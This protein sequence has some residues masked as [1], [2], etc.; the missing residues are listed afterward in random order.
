MALQSEIRRLHPGISPSDLE[1]MAVA[2]VQYIA[3]NYVLEK[4]GEPVILFQNTKVNSPIPECNPFIWG[5]FV[6]RVYI[7]NGDK[8]IS[9][10]VM[11]SRPKYTDMIYLR[12]DTALDNID[13]VTPVPDEYQLSVDSTISIFVFR[14]GEVKELS[15]TVCEPNF[16]CRNDDSVESIPI[17]NVIVN[18]PFEP[19]DSGAPAMVS[20]DGNF[21][22]LGTLN[23]G[24][25]HFG[26]IILFGQTEERVVFGGDLPT[27]PY[28]GTL[29]PLKGPKKPK[30]VITY[31]YKVT[32][33]KSAYIEPGL[34]ES[35]RAKLD[36]FLNDLGTGGLATAI[37]EL[38]DAKPQKW[39]GNDDKKGS[40][41]LRL[42]GKNRIWVKSSSD[43]TADSVTTTYT[44]IEV[45]NRHH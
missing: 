8:E 23:F 4:D 7:Q 9:A 6:D 18:G 17:L 22:F 32:L 42:D 44:I 33:S 43:E 15:T 2:V 27:D 39:K 12:G 16:K 10:I 11:D 25:H 26:E 21:Y 34:T 20:D 30:P 28:L 37:K 36:Q 40:I 3:T 14:D 24:D 31:H 45:G 38:G 19:G 5:Y 1:K 41:E 13:P 29:P 35:S